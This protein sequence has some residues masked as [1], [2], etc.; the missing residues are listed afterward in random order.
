MAKTITIDI[1]D[2]G[3]A[4]VSM[5]QDGGE[6]E[7]MEFASATEALDAVEQMLEGETE[8][9]E[10]MWEQEAAAREAPM[11]EEDEEMM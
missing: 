11:T 10:A 9:P 1:A 5:M 6:P 3:T 2:D 7:M 8:T 4:S